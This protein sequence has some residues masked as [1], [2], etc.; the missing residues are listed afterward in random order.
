MA[1]LKELHRNWRAV[2][3]FVWR[4]TIVGQGI[5]NTWFGECHEACPTTNIQRKRSIY[6]TFN[7]I[8]DEGIDVLENEI[9]ECSR[10]VLEY[11]RDFFI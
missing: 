11:I 7:T 9:N 10:V 8:E 5:P 3:Y 6:R 1:S 4:C 2:S